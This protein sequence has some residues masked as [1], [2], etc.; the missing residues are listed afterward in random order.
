MNHLS[1]FCS[2]HYF[3][4][5][6]LFIRKIFLKILFKISKKVPV[7]ELQGLFD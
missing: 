3:F 6:G 1:I 5:V 7:T 2:D 4:K